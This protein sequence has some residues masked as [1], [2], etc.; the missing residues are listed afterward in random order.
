MEDQNHQKVQFSDADFDQAFR[1]DPLTA[2]DMLF[3]DM[4]EKEKSAKEK[5]E[6]LKEER[7]KAEK[8]KEE[9]KYKEWTER[10]QKENV[11]SPH[12]Y[13]KEQRAEES[14]HGPKF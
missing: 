7:E 2:M 3:E 9:T 11:V 13:N 5:I 12:V 14:H 4:K 10:Q 8:E 1:C 6:L